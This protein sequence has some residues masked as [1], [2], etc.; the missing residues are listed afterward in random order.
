MKRVGL[1]VPSSNT[2]M[3]LE[4][5]QLLLRHSDLA[6]SGCTFHS[7]RARLHTVDVKSLASMVDDGERCI[8]EVADADVD[9]VAYACLVALMARGPGSHGPIEQR[10]AKIA[11][12]AENRTVPVVS[13]AGALVRTL[14]DLGLT[15]IALVAPYMPEL[16]QLVIEY[17]RNAGIAVVDSISLCVP[18]N[19]KVGR[20]GP[21]NLP[22]QVSKLDLGDAQ[23][24]VLSACVQMQ[25]LPA[26][27]SV[28]QT[29]GLPV[30][31]AVTSTAREVLKAL[32]LPPVVAGGGAALAAAGKSRSDA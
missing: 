2:T 6:V 7:S 16:T 12:E 22:R 13:S 4:L 8:T 31:T 23:G 9:V 18:D 32:G 11:A 3:E 20:L 17:V 14:Q 25:S 30:V 21:E 28:E 29:T 19:L 10:F 5:P 15:R 24:I 27:D 1:V 26:V